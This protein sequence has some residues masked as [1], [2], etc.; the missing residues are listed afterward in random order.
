MTMLGLI[1]VFAMNVTIPLFLQS[2]RDLAPLDASLTLDR[3][4]RL[5][6]AL[7]R[8]WRRQRPIWRD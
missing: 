6:S 7:V 1:F 4:I 5:P 3:S 8:V 2:A